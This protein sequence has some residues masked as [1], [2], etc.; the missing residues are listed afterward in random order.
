MKNTE[1]E[2]LF[3]G[4]IG[5][6]YELLRIMHPEAA[7]MSQ[8]VGELVGSYIHGKPA[9]NEV[10]NVLEL[11]CGTGITTLALVNSRKDIRLT[12]VDNEPTML[13]QARA[14]LV[15]WLST[16]KLT[17]IENDALSALQD[18]A[19]DSLDIIAS[20]YAIH[21]FLDSYRE[22]VLAEIVR[23]LKPGGLFVNS[24]RYALDDFEAHTQHVQTEVKR[25]F[26]VLTKMNRPDVL[27]QWIVHLF[28][29][30]SPH[31]IM[32]TKPSLQAMEAVGFHPIEEHYRQGINAL[33]T[34]IKPHT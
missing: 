16:G 18:L 7:E 32:R 13:N 23:V 28:S 30:E 11:G 5:E 15:Q 34:G 22:K 33:I 20:A 14:N 19:T 12:S 4:L 27:E 21:N 10:L 31:H 24:D 8:R 3:S 17:L 9:E 1:I 26:E 6:E 2:R 25:Y 29:D